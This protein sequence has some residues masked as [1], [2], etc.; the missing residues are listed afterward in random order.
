MV[1]SLVVEGD[2]HQ[3]AVCER[4]RE[5][6]GPAGVFEGRPVVVT[7]LEGDDGLHA[8]Q[9]ALLEARRLVPEEALRAAEPRGSQR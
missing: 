9:V 4:R 6:E 5:I 2:R 3:I 7:R 8:G 1:P